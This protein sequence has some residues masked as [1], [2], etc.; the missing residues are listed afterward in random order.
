MPE[1]PVRTLIS[2]LRYVQARG[3]L[4]RLGEFVRPIGTKPLLV[5]DDVVWGIV[6]DTVAVSF[7]DQDLPA[8]APG[9][10]RTP[11]PRRSTGSRARSTSS[12]PT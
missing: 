1:V 8:T 6:Q 9:S 4:T 5:A 10:A 2:P 7:Q 11:P 3:A 12:A